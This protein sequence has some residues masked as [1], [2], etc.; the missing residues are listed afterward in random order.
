MTP[1]HMWLQEMERRLNLLNET[2]SRMGAGQA[3]IVQLLQD[4]GI[5]DDAQAFEQSVASHLAQVDQAREQA[6]R[7]LY[8]SGQNEPL[9]PGTGR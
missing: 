9:P 6:K 3:A 5:L 1:D 4:K 2:I 8:T 7:R